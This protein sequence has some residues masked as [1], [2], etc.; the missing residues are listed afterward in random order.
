MAAMISKAQRAW[1]RPPFAEGAPSHKG[2]A[3]P[4]PRALQLIEGFPVPA[5]PQMQLGLRP[6]SCPHLPQVSCWTLFQLHARHSQDQELLES[7]VVSK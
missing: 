6:S 1:L 7:T 3:Q 2:H 4:G 5:V